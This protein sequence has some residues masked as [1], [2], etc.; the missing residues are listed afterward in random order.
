VAAELDAEVGELT[1]PEPLTAP[2]EQQSSSR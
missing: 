1:V 2:A